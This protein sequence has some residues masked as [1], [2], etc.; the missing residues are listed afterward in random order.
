MSR[1]KFYCDCGM[2]AVMRR[3]R[4]EII[5]D[6]EWTDMHWQKIE[7]DRHQLS[8]WLVDFHQ[9]YIINDKTNASCIVVPK[10]KK[11]LL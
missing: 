2:R 3:L 4:Q 8:D 10:D 11:N 5:I 1:R 9:N 6:L 7:K